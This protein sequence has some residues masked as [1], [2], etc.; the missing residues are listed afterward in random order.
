MEWLSKNVWQVAALLVAV[1]SLCVA[2]WRAR[3]ARLD[4][5]QT[6]FQKG[7]EMFGGTDTAT[8]LGGLYELQQLA[9][10]Y[11]KEYHVVVMKVLTGYVREKMRASDV[12]E[13][14]GLPDIR[15]PLR[16]RAEEVLRVIGGRSGRGIKEERDSGYRVDLTEVDARGMQLP[17]CDFSDINGSGSL[18]SQA[19]LERSVFRSAQLRGTKFNGA[20]LRSANLSQ[21][22][23][24]FAYMAGADLTFGSLAGSRM[25]WA[26]IP[27]SLYMCD[28]SDA[29]MFE[30]R[31]L[32]QKTLDSADRLIRTPPSIVAC[33]DAES[34]DELKWK[35][36]DPGPLPKVAEVF[37]G[38][39]AT[40]VSERALA[41]VL[42]RRAP[43]EEVVASQKIDEGLRFYVERIGRHG[44]GGKYVVY[45]WEMGCGSSSHT[46][47][48]EGDRE[49]PALDALKKHVEEHR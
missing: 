23:L 10:R 38:R 30:V 9:K 39:R 13:G 7:A 42:P 32:Q 27:G 20:R 35:G 33:L 1:V 29:R 48:Y 37:G 2:Y 6:R 21:A 17:D 18:F 44:H 22:D 24:E 34:G 46:K 3:T 11:P 19:N 15:D 40:P 31:G 26:D 43:M 4:N 16:E 28:L 45:R 12:A 25:R 47:L 41:R 36:G 49:E 8:F 14:D 5:L